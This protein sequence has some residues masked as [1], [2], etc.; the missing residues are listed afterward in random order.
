MVY[1]ACILIHELLEVRSLFLIFEV[2]HTTTGTRTTAEDCPLFLRRAHQ[3][4]KRC[5]NHRSLCG[6][7]SRLFSLSE[8]TFLPR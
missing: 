7:F 4:G 2:A 5:S 8:P 1:K 6:E 3:E